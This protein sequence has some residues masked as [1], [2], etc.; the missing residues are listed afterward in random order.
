MMAN[1][2]ETRYDDGRL[3]GV[4][5][6]AWRDAATYVRAGMTQH[7]EVYLT[8]GDVSLYLHLDTARAIVDQLVERLPAVAEPVEAAA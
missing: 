2:I 1:T 8:V 5:F 7:N 3:A 4:N 6:Y